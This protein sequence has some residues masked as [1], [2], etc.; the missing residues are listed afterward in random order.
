MSYAEDVKEFEGKSS[1]QSI[2]L[3]FNI[4]H[5]ENVC[6]VAQTSYAQRHQ[7]TIVFTTEVLYTRP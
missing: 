1:D 7:A 6:E 3:I 4:Y 2:V 5:E